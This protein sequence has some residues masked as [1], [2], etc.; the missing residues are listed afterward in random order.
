MENLELEAVK[1]MLLVEE[2]RLIQLVELALTQDEVRH[3]II[4]TVS[5]PISSKAYL[6]KLEGLSG[7]AG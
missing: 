3:A 2:L 7:I 4:Y 6:K 5:R 1:K